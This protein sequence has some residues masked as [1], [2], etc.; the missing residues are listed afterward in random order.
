MNNTPLLLIIVITALIFIGGFLYFYPLDEGAADLRA[1]AQEY[2][3]EQNVA[4]VEISRST[5]YIKVTS[6]L[7]GGGATYYPEDGE[8]PLQCPVVGPDAMSEACKNILDIT[9]W[10]V[11]CTVEEQ[12]NNETN[13]FDKTGNLVRNNPGME[14]GVWHLVFEEPGAPALSVQLQF[15]SSSICADGA[16]NNTCDPEELTEGGRV[17]ILGEESGE[18]V[19]RVIRLEPST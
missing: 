16:E 5:G 1:R 4:A 17:H 15:T 8:E 3:G 7:L 6:S 12:V 9:D 18:G 13:E 11:V 10:E 19:I 14:P 2:C